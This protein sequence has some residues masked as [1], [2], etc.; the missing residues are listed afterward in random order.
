[1]N[2]LEKL[3]MDYIWTEGQ[4]AAA[5]CVHDTYFWG[6]S[7]ALELSP[8][9]K[10]VGTIAFFHSKRDSCVSTDSSGFSSTLLFLPSFRLCLCYADL[11]QACYKPAWEREAYMPWSIGKKWIWDSS[12]PY[13]EGRYSLRPSDKYFEEL[14]PKSCGYVATCCQRF[15][16]LR[17]LQCHTEEEAGAGVEAGA[18]SEAGAT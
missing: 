17:A 5:L 10:E 14:G 15:A 18:G 11:K 7:V 16:W 6:L 9:L 12:F 4:W 1:M 3:N 8:E 2:S 13:R